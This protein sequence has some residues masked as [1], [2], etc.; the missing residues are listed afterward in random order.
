MQAHLWLADR[1]AGRGDA[2]EVQAQLAKATAL[3]AAI[4]S[5]IQ[6]AH[7]AEIARA[8][9][10]ID[11]QQRFAEQLQWLPASIA[12]CQ[13]QFGADSRR[14]GELK[15]RQA[16]ALLRMGDGRQALAVAEQLTPQLSQ[17]TARYARFAA[18]Y[19]RVHILAALG[20]TNFDEPAVQVLMAMLGDDST[21]R[22]PPLYQVP[23]LISMALLQLR[24][25]DVADAE[26]WLAQADAVIATQGR[27]SLKAESASLDAARGLTLQARG[28]H[29]EALVALGARCQAP[30]PAS[31]LASISGLN[32]V[33]SLVATGQKPQ[34]MALVQ[35][36]LTRFGSSLGEDA[37]NTRRARQ[38]LQDL[39]SPA[40][41]Q[42]AWTGGQIFISGIR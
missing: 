32:C 1:A 9:I 29:H 23:G 2:A 5:M 20:L 14:C 34:A 21:N 33:R 13:R 16:W 12:A 27:E 31:P 8:R 22:L 15:R 18:A 37:P 4:D 24:T 3:P 25:G 6:A 39:Q 19:L 40:Y 11:V 30:Q 10:D 26:R 36:T 42:P 35:A 38:L 28:K 41:R 7:A 17:S